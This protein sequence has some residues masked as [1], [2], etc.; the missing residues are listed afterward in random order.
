MK[1]TLIILGVLGLALQVIFGISEKALAVVPE[2]NLYQ[3]SPFTSSSRTIPRVLIVLSKDYKMFLQAYNGLVDIDKDGRIDTGFNPTV[4]YTGYFDPYSCYK[5]QGTVSRSGDPS[6]Y[7]L[8]SGPTQDDDSQEALDQARS[9]ALGVGGERVKAARS[10]PGICQSPHTNLGGNFSGNWLNF[11]TASRM[12]VIRKILYGGS[13][14]VDETNKTFLEGSF[15]TRDSNTWG[16]DVLAD[17]RWLAETPMSVYYDISKYTPF[18]KPE[19][20]SAHFF[21]RVKNTIGSKTSNFPVFEYILNANNSVFSSTQ[22]TG[23]NGRYFDWVLS[24]GPNPSNPLLKSDVTKID[25]DDVDK[26]L[27]SYTVRVQVCEPGNLG[28]GEDC[29]EYPNGQLKPVGL[30]QKNGENGNMYFGLLSGS[31]SDSTRLKGGVLRNHISSISDSIDVNTGQIIKDGLIWNMDTFRIAGANNDGDV[32]ENSSQH[33]QNTAS[34]GNPI[35]EMLFEGV[36]YFA[37]LSQKSNQTALT[38]TAAFLPSSEVNYNSYA[39]LPTSDNNATFLT[40]WKKLPT[41]PAG[42]CSKP[43]ILLISDVDSDSDGDTAVNGNNDLKMEVLPQIQAPETLPNF[44]LAQY[45]NT[46]TNIEGVNDGRAFFYSTGE[47]DNC[48]PK[49]LT[50]LIEVNGICPYRPAYLGSYSSAA[51]AYFAHTH[52]FGLMDRELGVDIYTVTM[53]PTFP[54]LDFPLFDEDG[55]VLKKITI[56]P[57]SLSSRYAESLRDR[58]LSFLNY[59]ILEWWVDAKGMP[60]HVR[61]KVNYEDI[62]AGNDWDMDV[63]MDYTIDLLTKNSPK[64]DPNKSFD[65]EAINNYA[66]EFKV[67]GEHYNAFLPQGSEPF[68][69]PPNEVAGLAIRSWRF[70]AAASL[71]MALGYSISGSTRDG[72]YMD[73]G[74]FGSGKGVITSVEGGKNVSKYS[75]PPTCNWPKGY[76]GATEDNGTN[77][78]VPFA[79]SSTYSGDYGDITKASTRT[80]KF[81]DNVAAAGSYLETPLYLAAKYGGFQDHNNNG[82]PDPGEWEGSDGAPRNYFQASNIAELPAKLEAAFNDIARS[83]STGTAT[84]ASVNSVLGG[85]VSIQTAFYPR[86]VAPNNS[87]EINWVGTVYALFLDKFGNL[88]EDNNG[89]GQL[90]DEDAVVTFNSLKTPPDPPPSCYSSGSAI[91]RCQINASGAITSISSVSNIHQLKP[92][93]DVGKLLFTTDPASR[94]I[95]YINPD[96]N[97]VKPFDTDTETVTELTKFLIY[98]NYKDILPPPSGS[99]NQS[100]AATATKLIQYIKG[101]DIAEWRSRTIDNPWNPGTDNVWRLGDIINSKPVIVG[102]PAFNYDF[103]YGDKTYTAF[104]AQYGA[105]RQVAY[106]GSN[107]GFLHAINMGKFGS[108]TQGQVGFSGGDLGKEL[109]ALIPGSALP[110]LQWLADPG[111]IHSYYVD[112]K[113]MVADIK[114]DNGE[115]RT[116]LICGLRLGGRAIESPTSTSSSPKSFFSEVF[117]LDVTN[118]DLNPQLL[119]RFSAQELGLSVGLPAVVTSGG[120][121]YAVVP[122]GPA[123]DTLDSNGVLKFGN[124]SPYDGNSSQKARLFILGADSGDLYNTLIADEDNSF[125]NDP[126]APMN[127]KRNTSGSWNDETIYYGMT[128]TRDGACLDK[129]G[130]YRLQMVSPADSIPETVDGAPLPVSEW[131]LKP[132][133]MVDRPVTGAVNSTLDYKGNL[134]VIFATGRLWGQD[135]ISPCAKTNTELCRE[136]HQQYLYGIKE[137]LING[138]MTFEDQTSKIKTNVL[139]VTPASV[140]SS[141]QVSGLTNILVFNYN[142]LSEKL[143]ASAFK[144]YKR[145]LNM[146]TVLS[147]IDSNELNLNQP[148]ITSVGAGRSILGFTTYEPTAAETCGDYGQGYMYVLDPFTGSPAPYLADSFKP[149]PAEQAPNGQ[150]TLTG[151]RISGGVS[152][153]SGQPSAATFVVLGDSVIIRTSTTENSIVDVAIPSEQKM[154]NNIISWREVFNTGFTLPKGIMTKD[155]QINP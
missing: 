108:L 68:S 7:F 155:L 73:S 17:N 35:G 50:S 100:K 149:L 140:Y 154:V 59:Y 114:G 12:D 81:A 45:L 132:F 118:P 5:Y 20:D 105:R 123:M 152:T 88:R 115:W 28:D 96:T 2:K 117:A 42:E 82:Q 150:P 29:R 76:G 69:I 83:V 47:R 133:A 23:A 87:K 86:Y 31:Y 61:I 9:T 25:N 74:H 58:I 112:M 124:L 138:R 8:R 111:Y 46:I 153:G 122:S 142:D 1:F 37:R 75:T 116:I 144:G 70:T 71:S 95:F 135:D 10:N 90:D 89:D 130:V 125:F 91:S 34:W 40:D 19:I 18:P 52:N 146:A 99:T 43:V 128:I 139:D 107:D 101:T 65:S 48:Q 54:A 62:T 33:Y 27:K 26:A 49:T 127:L 93:W 6:G 24:E 14:Y 66:G 13:R 148:K 38:P 94:N 60:Y 22:Y 141:G 145:R 39:G 102:Q 151:S 80:F 11:L 104:K 56:L 79:S 41:L 67:D 36:R 136:N 21:A 51:V 110:H 72:T 103:I 57:A 92:V 113:P 78:F 32:A 97:E 121:W 143:G 106:F 129:G 3:V 44:N 64:L 131:K 98:D 85:G 120:K 119:W 53:S 55:I 15:V 84:A 147:G 63:M 137:E 134:W 109:W 16:T 30:L 4:I 77:C 126:Y